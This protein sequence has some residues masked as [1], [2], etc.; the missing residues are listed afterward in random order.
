MADA[1]AAL[2]NDERPDRETLKAAVRE[3]LRR[4][5]ERSPGHSVEVRVPPYGAVQCVE[6]PR[7][8]RGTPPNVVECDPVAFLELAAG[9]RSFAEAVANGQVSASGVR[10]DLSD[11]LPLL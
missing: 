3:L 7:H 6:G 1:I 10:A 11:H 8:R 5:A 9:R 2:D 4:L